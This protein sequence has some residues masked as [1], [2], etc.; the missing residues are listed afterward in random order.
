LQ[1]RYEQEQ[2]RQEAV[3]Y[4]QLLAQ[5]LVQ[6]IISAFRVFVQDARPCRTIGSAEPSDSG[7]R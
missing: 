1:E 7:K 5:D 2:R 6:A 4:Q 3:H